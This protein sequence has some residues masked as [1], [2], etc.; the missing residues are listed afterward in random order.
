MVVY[1]EAFESAD[2][3]QY[4]S[5][6]DEYDALVAE[7]EAMASALQGLAEDT[8]A[9]DTQLTAL[10]AKQAEADAKLTE[11]E[12]AIADVTAAQEDA[13]GYLAGAANKDSMIDGAVVHAVNGMLDGKSDEFAHEALDGEV[14]HDS[15]TGVAGIINPPAD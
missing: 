10:A 2:W 1:T 13:A 15:E 12:A 8:Q 11:A 5:L 9:Y 3:D 7:A 14:I 4:N 6:M